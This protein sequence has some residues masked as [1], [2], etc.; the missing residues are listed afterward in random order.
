MWHK[1]LLQGAHIFTWPQEELAKLH[2]LFIAFYPTH[3]CASSHH[4]TTPTLF[5]IHSLV[6][7]GLQSPM[8][9]PQVAFAFLVP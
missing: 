6:Q 1:L 7:W 5:T 8:P 2:A 4:E 3:G 9:F